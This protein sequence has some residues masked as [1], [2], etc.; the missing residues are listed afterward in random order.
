MKV[1]KG[2]GNTPVQRDPLVSIL[3]CVY[4]QSSYVRQTVESVLNQTYRNWEWVVLDDG[5]TDGTANIIQ[6]AGDSR[7][8]YVFQEHGGVHQLTRTFNNALQLC[9]GDLI[10][11]LD[12]DDYW[13]RNKL[14]IQVDH[15]Q[16]SD[17]ILSYGEAWL[18]NSNGRKK[19]YLYLPTDK[20]IACNDPP[21]S[22]LKG[23]LLQ[24]S[25]FIV[26]S[27][28]MYR[29]HALS[30]IGGFVEAEGLCQDYPTWIRLSLEGKFTPVPLP[31][32]YYRKHSSS[33]SLRNP[34]LFLDHDIAF[35]RLFLQLYRDELSTLGFSY[36]RAG[37]ESDWEKIKTYLPYNTAL[38]LL[39]NGFF[40]ESE[41]EFARFLMKMPSL[42]H[43]LIYYLIKLSALIKIDVVNPMTFLKER[44]RKILFGKVFLQ[45]Q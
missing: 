21:G 22:A 3:T 16:D 41:A 11:T 18:V 24:H 26:N 2:Q 45:R 43:K 5:S 31:L 28:V 17:A 37:I 14:E 23:L 19:R 15:F 12:G 44:L 32:G 34:E 27:T 29:K 7:I 6:K 39:M 4:N 38:Y 36:D 13:P 9:N 10:A 1:S 35:F 40:A 30:A 8:R 25:C 33:V 20:S 42:K